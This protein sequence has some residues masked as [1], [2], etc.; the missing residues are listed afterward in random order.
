[1]R[2]FVKNVLNLTTKRYLNSSSG[3]TATTSPS[4]LVLVK[5]SANANPTVVLFCGLEFFS[6]SVNV[7]KILEQKVSMVASTTA[8][9]ATTTIPSSYNRPDFKVFACSIDKIDK[10]VE[11]TKC[12]VIVPLMG[13]VTRSAITRGA[14]NGNLKLIQ[15]WG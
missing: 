11:E 15:Q 7:S 13:K 2:S 12:N 1:M 5:D 10:A 4:N 14:N 6:A 8:T 3:A 9:T